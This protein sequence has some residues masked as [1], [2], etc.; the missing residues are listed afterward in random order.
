MTVKP[1][2][3]GSNRLLIFH[4][5]VMNIGKVTTGF[6]SSMTGL[7][8]T[9]NSKVFGEHVQKVAPGGAATNRFKDV[10]NVTGLRVQH[11]VFSITGRAGTGIGPP[12]MPNERAGDFAG[13]LRA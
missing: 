1:K 7:E 13:A 5:S 12:M 11:E 9:G 3:R 2:K 6:A 4:S 8:I 10:G